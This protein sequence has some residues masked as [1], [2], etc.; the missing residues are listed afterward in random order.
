MAP[1]GDDGAE[2]GAVGDFH[3]A[4]LERGAHLDIRL[5]VVERPYGTGLC[6]LHLRNGSLDLT[7]PNGQRC[8]LAEVLKVNEGNELT[9]VGK[10]HGPT[11]Q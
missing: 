11:N 4:H 7:S 6:F 9:F 3:A 5:V 10:R 8:I 2:S 1:V